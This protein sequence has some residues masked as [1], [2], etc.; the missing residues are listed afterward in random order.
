MVNLHKEFKNL[1]IAFVVFFL[2]MK[3]LFFKES[4]FVTLRLTFS[5]FWAFILPGYM[6]TLI[7]DLEFLERFSLG[8]ILGSAVIG[9][10]AYYLG[11]IGIKIKY[12]AIFF[13]PVIMILST[14]LK[15][16]NVL[17]KLWKR[18]T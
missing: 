12:T 10:S 1:L 13:P 17:S 18:N 8:L 4:F 3:L 15:D 9:I 14:F 5:L 7:W 6:L 2:I 11:L 16:K